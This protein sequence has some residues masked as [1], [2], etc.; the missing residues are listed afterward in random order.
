MLLQLL[1]FLLLLSFFFSLCHPLLQPFI[2]GISHGCQPQGGVN[3]RA[4]LFQGV[5][6]APVLGGATCLAFTGSAGASARVTSPALAAMGRVPCVIPH[7]SSIWSCHLLVRCPLQEPPHKCTE[8][9]RS[10]RAALS[11]P[12]A[13]LNL[14]PSPQS[15]IFSRLLASLLT[16]DF[17][18]ASR[19][20]FR[21][22]DSYTLPF[23]RL[24]NHGPLFCRTSLLFRLALLLTLGDIL[25]SPLNSWLNL[26]CLVALYLS[27]C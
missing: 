22:G 20:A 23:S 7:P 11:L 17:A 14:T 4:L 6:P 27:D 16:A 8:V 2:P 21:L 18:I 26:S 9:P 15:G 13:S 5:Q 10:A 24:V 12:R 1:H 19:S 25:P 3:I